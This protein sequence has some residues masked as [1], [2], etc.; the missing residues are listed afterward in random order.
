VNW[1]VLFRSSAF[2]AALGVFLCVTGCDLKPEA[3]LRVGAAVSPG[4]ECLFLARSLGLL[5]GKPIKLVEYSSTPEVVRAF[6]N[7][8][9][10][11]AALS[12]DEF[13]RLL[14]HEP[15]LRAILVTGISRGADDLI[16][17]AAHKEICDLRGKRIGVEVN[18]AGVFLLARALEHAGMSTS[19]IQVVPL[20]RDE[21]VRAFAK[22]E[23]H[24]IVTCEPER[25][26]ILRQGG[27]SLF[28]SARIPGEILEFLV[29]RKS[30]LEKRKPLL[31]ELVQRWFD[32][33]SYLLSHPDHAAELVA[34][35][36]G[37][38]VSEFAESLNAVDLLS[39]E[40][41]RLMLGDDAAATLQ[42]LVAIQA[43]MLRTGIVARTNSLS[44]L[45]DGGLLP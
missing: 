15:D 33:R 28:D 24:A 6:E 30:V 1:N 26:K 12:A 42:T 44:G 36:E 7:H 23:L 41:N 34:P 3:P 22:G 37:V 2:A 39:L 19:D 40:Q 4:Y 29:V 31:R 16:A 11:V 27:T 35:R 43:A 14:S 25:G 21:H 32:A 18:T 5:E 20:D 17:T 38:T 13:L 10:E 9:I 45:L 8:A